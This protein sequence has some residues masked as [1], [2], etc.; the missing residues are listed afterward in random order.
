MTRKSVLVGLILLILILLPIDWFSPT[1]FLL[2]E[3][4][5]KPF[6]LVLIICALGF[7]TNGKKNFFSEVN[8]NNSLHKYLFG[9]ITC[10]TIAFLFNIFF[11]SPVPLEGRSQFFQYFAQTAMLLMFIAVLQ[12]MLIIFCESWLRAVVQDLLPIAACFHLFFYAMESMG[13]FSEGSPGLLALFRNEQG[14]IDRP[15]GLMSEPSYYGT[16]AA[17]YAV[18]LMIFGGKLN[19]LRKII[20]LALL[21]TALMIHAK[22][23]FI[24]L[25]IQLLYFSTMR[26]SEEE[27]KIFIIIIISTITFIIIALVSGS[28]VNLDRNL[29][30]IMRVGSNILALNVALDGY[31][32]LGIGIGQFHFMYRPEFA[33]EY[34]FLSQEALDQMDGITGSRAST[35]NLPLRILVETGLTGLTLA[36]IM[37]F[38]VFWVLRND[39]DPATRIGLFFVAGSIGFLMTQDTYCLPSLAFGLA[40]ALTGV[41]KSVTPSQSIST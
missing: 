24:V 25:G 1:G 36:S 29:S 22:T 16:F 38:Q 34:L 7:I 23:M 21:L 2:R 15:S 33:P 10:G 40:L 37:I 27:R 26:K 18:P 28:L 12:T 31:G 5:S 17:M 19:F 4:G 6:N 3:A 11:M 20:S 9:I 39:T 13:V 32:L 14:L 30:S 8:T 41:T 35:F